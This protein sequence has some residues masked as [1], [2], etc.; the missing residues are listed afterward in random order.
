VRRWGWIEWDGKVG[1][2]SWTVK[3]RE[4]EEREGTAE[5]RGRG[6]YVIS[7]VKT[8]VLLENYPSVLVEDSRTLSGLSP[9]AEGSKNSINCRGIKWRKRADGQKMK[10]QGGTR[11]RNEIS[12]GESFSVSLA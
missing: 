7:G 10:E 8:E 2:L 4:K 11:R 9:E 3:V 5:G 6:G 12:Q 1:F